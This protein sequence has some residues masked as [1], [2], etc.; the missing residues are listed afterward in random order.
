VVVYI[1]VCEERNK[2]SVRKG[3]PK[4]F[5]SIGCVTRKSQS[6]IALS[7][8]LQERQ[9]V[10]SLEKEEKLCRSVVETEKTARR[11]ENQ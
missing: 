1:D 3:N 5:I 10:F 6:K 9:T 2:N 11:I 8:E 4:S 7:T